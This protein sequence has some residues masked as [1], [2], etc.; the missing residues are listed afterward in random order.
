[1]SHP[2]LVC[3]IP[4]ETRGYLSIE[5]RGFTRDSLSWRP[6]YSHSL[7]NFKYLNVVEGFLNANSSQENNWRDRL[8]KRRR[9]EYG[10]G[11]E[12]I[13]ESRS[14]LRHLGKPTRHNGESSDHPPQPKQDHARH[15]AII[16]ILPGASKHCSDTEH[17]TYDCGG[18]SSSFGSWQQRSLA[19][20]SATT[21]RRH[22]SS[23]RAATFR[24]TFP[25]HWMYSH[26]LFMLKYSIHHVINLALFYANSLKLTIDFSQTAFYH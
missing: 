16:Y 7:V 14:L 20:R 10:H 15:G 3:A 5:S 23:S 11:T 4:R 17:P 18:H 8:S 26:I 6:F 9:R 19:R 24:F 25:Q 12:W 2:T 22:T 21:S 1:M 13:D